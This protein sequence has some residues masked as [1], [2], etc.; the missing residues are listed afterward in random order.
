MTNKQFNTVEDLV[1]E[2]EY[3]NLFDAIVG[4]TV[5]KGNFPKALSEQR[6]EVV[7]I[8][9]AIKDIQK[10]CAK[11]QKE[12]ERVYAKESKVRE[13]AQEKARAAKQAETDGAEATN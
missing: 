1:G 13:K 6:P 12:V 4:G 10:E 5:T 2:F 3:S 9:D 8:I 7:G 11:I